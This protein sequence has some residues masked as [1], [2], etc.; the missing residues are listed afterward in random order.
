MKRLFDISAAAILSVVLAPILLLI[1]VT[2]KLDSRGPAL[3][4][5]RRVG[6]DN[7]L[8]EMAKFRSMHVGTPQVATHLMVGAENHVTTVG[9]FLRKTSLDELPQLYNVLRGEL[10]LVGPRPALFNQYDLIETRT[11]RGV[12][13]M[14]PGITGW[15]Q[16]C[17]RDELAI[18]EK[19]E[20]DAYYCQNQSFRF[21][22][23]IL[24]RTV[25]AV[26]ARHGGDH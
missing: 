11:L 15:A 13:R 18:P 19:V 1:A 9:S 10:S 22:L 17:G 7:Q 16:V 24:W 8:F 25:L 21:D 4:W 12:H 20:Y 5:S 23:A 14:L 2:I 26:V 3:H 6:R